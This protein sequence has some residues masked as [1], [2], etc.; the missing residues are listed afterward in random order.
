[1]KRRLN[2]NKTVYGSAM[3]PAMAM[4]AGVMATSMMAAPASALEKVGVQAAVHGT[5]SLIAPE[6]NSKRS[7]KSGDGVYFLETVESGVDSGLQI[8]LLD[9]TTFTVGPQSEIIIDEMVYDPSGNSKLIV[10]VAKGAFR[11]ISGEIAKQNPENVTIRT[12]NGEIGIR[13]TSFF[14]VSKPETGGWYFGLLGPGPN[15]N[16]GDKAGGIVF[17]NE[18]G[19]A[20]VRRSGFGFSVEPGTAPSAVGEIPP[21][22]ITQFEKQV[23]AAMLPAGKDIGGTIA[24]AKN[25]IAEGSFSDVATASG[26]LTAITS[27]V[28]VAET[29]SQNLQSVLSGTAASAANTA[30]SVDSLTPLNYAQLRGYTGVVNYTQNNVPMYFGQFPNTNNQLSAALIKDG[31]SRL[32]G[33]VIGKYDF[34][35]VANFTTRNISGSYDNI[36]V[37]TL[38]VS[39]GTN[40]VPFNISYSAQS[41]ALAVEMN[42]YQTSIGGGYDGDAMISFIESGTSL[43]NALQSLSLRETATS[44]EVAIGASIIKP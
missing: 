21:E 26:N 7:G 16:T 4:V 17:K 1:M 15:N 41:D 5:V 42:S 2:A 25:T 31:L 10:N 39:T 18:F 9:E 23:S 38:G 22:I 13:G 43:P 28:V 19:N 24:D 40:A 8:L 29:V 32:N 11:Y 44:K 3:A 35:M 30:A 33:T 12:P 34:G 20:E 36:N 6:K 27:D 14:A 37:P